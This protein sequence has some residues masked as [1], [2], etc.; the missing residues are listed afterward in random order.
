MRL[1]ERFPFVA[2]WTVACT[3]LALGAEAISHL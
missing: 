3:L 2:P 1:V